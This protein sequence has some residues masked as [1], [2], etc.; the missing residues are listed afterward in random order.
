METPAQYSVKK[1]YTF[2]PV[3]RKDTFAF[4]SNCLEHDADARR[5]QVDWRPRCRLLCD[6]LGV[7]FLRGQRDGMP[8]KL[9]NGPSPSGLAKASSQFWIAHQHVDFFG[10][11]TGKLVR[12]DRLK[13]AFRVLFQ[14]H[15][16]PG[17]PV[18]NHLLN[19][20]DRAAHHGRLTGH[21][22]EVDNAERFVNGRAAENA[23]RR[24]QL[25]NRV[26]RDN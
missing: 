1:S 12:V 6:Q 24:V 10:E 25:I 8:T 14:W 11:V 19:A 4:L 23:G 18:D 17:L 20:T 26:L 2:G 9:L 15:Q 21:R 7:H 16:E 3:V 22:L 5:S 13:G